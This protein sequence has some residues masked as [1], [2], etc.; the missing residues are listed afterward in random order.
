MLRRPRRAR[1][2]GRSDYAPAT[3]TLTYYDGATWQSWKTFE[4]QSGY[5]SLRV[6]AGYFYNYYVSTLVTVPV[7]ISGLGT[8]PCRQTWADWSGYVK[9]RRGRAY[10]NLNT[11][12][13][14]AG[15]GCAYP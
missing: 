15:T 10:N 4:S 11:Y 8:F 12:L 5:Y 14:P 7:T 2:G 3:V 6:P 1:V 9:A 13:Q